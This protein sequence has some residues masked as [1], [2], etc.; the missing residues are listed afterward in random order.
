[1]KL[2]QRRRHRIAWLIVAPLVAVLFLAALAVK[3]PVPIAPL[4][5]GR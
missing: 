1:M 3:P 4:E 5:S 2:R